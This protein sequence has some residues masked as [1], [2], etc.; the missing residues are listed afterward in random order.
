M[1]LNQP[2]TQQQKHFAPDVKLIS[3]TDLQGRIVDC[4]D[5]FVAVS[6]FTREELIGQ[7]HNIVRHPDMPAQAF[8]TMWAQL[9]AGKPWMGIVKNR[10][11]NGDFYW[12]DAYVTPVTQTGKIVGYESVRRCPDQETVA[13]AQTLYDNLTSQKSAPFKWPKLRMIWPVLM[14]IVGIGLWWFVSSSSA[15]FWV[16]LNSISL[17]GYNLW[18]DGEQLKRLEQSL[19]HSFCDDVATQ[20][21]STWDG[22]MASI[23]V[24]LL[25]EQAHLDTVITRIEDA[26]KHV[27]SGARQALGQAG[28]TYKQLQ[29]QQLETEQVA[30]AMNEMSTT[31]NDVSGN[32]QISAEHAQGALSMA[33]ESARIGELTKQA[34]E[35]LGETVMQIRDSVLGVSKQT[36]RIADAAQIIEQI[37]EQTNLLALNAAIEAARA[38]EQ[39]RGFAVVADEVRH[40]AQRTQQ[41]TQE[42]HTIINELSDSTQ[43]AVNIAQQGEQESLSGIEQLA[44][45]TDMLGQIQQAVRQIHDMSMQIATSVEEQAAVSDDI[46]QQIVNIAGLANDSLDSA[47]S[48]KQ[49]SGE[50]SNVASEMYELVVRFQR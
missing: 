35:A 2:V 18:R 38:G 17:C 39:G 8:A 26:A 24:R 45:S 32:V 4:N 31:I 43:H 37:A 46:N 33:D 5:H 1:R 12:V 25:S 15:F 50:L 27:T 30:T 9:K 40:L 19:S 48:V 28:D 29:S 36:T 22:K 21:Y 10:C 34:I 49:V 6:G 47:D 3:V 42:I 20:I 44:Q 13:R 16:L 7:P 11:K 41:S 23:Q 14:S